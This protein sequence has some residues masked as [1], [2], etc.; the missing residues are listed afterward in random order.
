MNNLVVS[1][2]IDSFKISVKLDNFLYLFFWFQI[3]LFVHFCSDL[4]FILRLWKNNLHAIQFSFLKEQFFNH[5]YSTKS[6][7]IFKLTPGPRYSFNKKI[8]WSNFEKVTNLLK[9]AVCQIS[10]D[11]HEQP[12]LTLLFIFCL[13]AKKLYK[14]ITCAKK[15]GKNEKLMLPHLVLCRAKLIEATL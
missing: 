15:L 4:F 13:W 9:R 3:G 10:I 1:R 12:F 14:Y 7:K 6:Y 5:V 2:D 11:V 8:N